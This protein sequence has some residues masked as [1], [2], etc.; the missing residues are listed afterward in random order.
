MQASYSFWGN[1]YAKHFDFKR[2]GTLCRSHP[3]WFHHQRSGRRTGAVFNALVRRHWL[4]VECP[5]S[6]SGWSR[7]GGLGFA[8]LHQLQRVQWLRRV[9][10]WDRQLQHWRRT[11]ALDSQQQPAP[12]HWSIHVPLGAWPQWPP[13]HGN[14][15]AIMAEARVL[16]LEPERLRPMP[17]HFMLHS[18]CQLL[19]S[20]HRE[21]QRISKHIGTQVRSERNHWCLS[22]PTHESGLQR[23]HGSTAP[24]SS[25]Q[26]DQCPFRLL[27][28]CRRAI[29][30]SR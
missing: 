13:S 5:I 7:C 21:P 11:S 6:W 26:G 2:L 3:Y 12:C 24:G 8:E 19:R 1:F 22:L 14:D 4:W 9:Q 29:R 16:R 10:H 23:I 18:R 30:L 28:L 20:I 17:S 27:I 25:K 15:W